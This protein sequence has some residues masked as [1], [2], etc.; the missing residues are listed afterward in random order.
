MAASK[1]GRPRKISD[2]QLERAQQMKV[3]G[4]SNNEI[5]KI[6]HNTK[7]PTPSQRRNVSVIL[8]RK[9]SPI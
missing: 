6:L 4:R 1:R 8:K 9:Q 2:E 3:E 5:A 7:S